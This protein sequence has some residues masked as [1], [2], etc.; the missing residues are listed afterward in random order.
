M[1]N[2]F[3]GALSLYEIFA[4]FIIYSFLG[5]V[6]EVAF[7]AVTQ[8]KFVNRGFL[9][10]PV[11][12]I[13]GV[14]I[15]VIL[16]FLGD[17]A[18]R[19]WLVFLV[20]VVFCTLIEL[21]TGWALEKFFHDKWWDY[22]SRKFNFKGYICLEFSILWGIAVLLV[23]D[24][25]HPVVKLFTGIF[26]ETAGT[27]IIIV[28]LAALIA[29]LILTVLQV[30]K[31]NRKLKEIDE[32]AKAL[33]AGSDFIGGYVADAVLVAEAAVTDFKEKIGETKEK[34][35]EKTAETKETLERKRA[36]WKEKREN[37]I[38][39]IVAKMP[40]RILKAFPNLTSRSNPESVTLAKEG[41]ERIK[42]HKNQP[43]KD[44]KTKEAENGQE[45]EINQTE[46]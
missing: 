13:Y 28:A 5:W 42:T 24:G 19:F 34:I 1:Q 30:L 38:D 40:K 26:T 37:A 4:Y 35:G 46:D 45:R 8:G 3:I 2:I 33:R 16:L 29:D 20:G 14:G 31:F 6:V 44:G 21:V 9:N 18:D 23:V 10:G 17:W 25:V 43:L 11:C 15:T 22:S 7:H 12:P 39:A 36:E 32:A 41:M 27:V